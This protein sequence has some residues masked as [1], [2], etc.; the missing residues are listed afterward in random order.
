MLDRN[1]NLN[2][3]RNLLRFAFKSGLAVASFDEASL[4]A[5]LAAVGQEHVLCWWPSLSADGRDALARQLSGVN[6]DLLARLYRQA[7]RSASAAVAAAIRP[8]PV[9]RLPEEFTD[10]ERWQQAAARGEEA[11][12]AGQ[13]AILLVAGGQGTRLGFDGPKGTYPIAPLSG[14]TLFH[15]HAAKVLAL[16]RR[17]ESVIPLYV[18]TSPENDATTRQFFAQERLFGLEPAQVV[19]F[20]QGTMPAIDKDTGKLLMTAQ[21]QLA[22]SPNGHGGTLQAL[23]DH[24]HLADLRRRGIRYL[25][26]FQ[27]DNPMVKVTDAA[28]LGHHIE[29]GADLSLKV[30]AKTDPAEKV[31]VFVEVDGKPQVL[32]YSELPK[33]L[34]ERRATDG[35]LEIWAGSIAIHIFDVAFLERLAAGGQMLPFHRAVKKVPHLAED[36][37]L[38]QSEKPNGIKFEM[39]IFDAIPLAKKVLAVEC[40]R[41][42]EFEPLKNAEGENSP[43]SVRQAMSNLFGAWLQQAG[44]SVPR[45]PNGDVGVAIEISPLFALDAE[46]LRGNLKDMEAV[47]GPLLLENPP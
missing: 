18:M 19:F 36:G 3:N 7:D 21:S 35:T 8:A 11:L 12:K 41:H 47:S 25:F 38:V 13:V 9:L 26:Y 6:F 33:E 46:E 43:A 23:A 2:R 34:A 32:E 16:S 17:Y 42:E 30:V 24:G 15:I 22:L 37:K 10:W 27:V 1:L 44:V 20:E 29:A 40:D 28:F 4:R 14:K 45:H 39:F 5:R 31:G